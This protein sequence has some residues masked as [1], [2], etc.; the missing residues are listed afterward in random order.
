M[1]GPEG[2]VNEP[3]KAEPFDARPALADKSF[4]QLAAALSIMAVPS[5]DVSLEV[6]C[7]SVAY[8]N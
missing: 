3:N 1:G 7:C 5:I 8:D 6:A 4:L 2:I